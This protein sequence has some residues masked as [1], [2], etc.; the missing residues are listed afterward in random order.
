MLIYVF[1]IIR[2]LVHF[3]TFFYICVGSNE[4][5]KTEIIP[6]FII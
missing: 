6:V 3:L 1:M 4:T 5:R 2:F